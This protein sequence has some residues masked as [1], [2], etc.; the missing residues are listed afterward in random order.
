MKCSLFDTSVFKN[1]LNSSLN[2]TWSLRIVTIISFEQSSDIIACK[3]SD[4]SSL[5]APMAFRETSLGKGAEKDC[6]FRRLSTL[7]PYPSS[8]GS[9]STNM[10]PIIV[11]R[12]LSGLQISTLISGRVKA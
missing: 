10:T 3:N 2:K 11:Q 7:S 6:R 1:L 8:L 9:V 4:H 5:P 12:Y